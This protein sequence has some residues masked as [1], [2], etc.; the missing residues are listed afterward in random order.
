MEVQEEKVRPVNVAEL[1]WLFYVVGCARKIMFS[2][3]MKTFCFQCLST[4]SPFGSRNMSANLMCVPSSLWRTAGLWVLPAWSQGSPTP[5]R[6]PDSQTGGDREQCRAHVRYVVT[7][8]RGRKMGCFTAKCWNPAKKLLHGGW[9]WFL[10]LN[11]T[12][13]L[14]SSTPSVSEWWCW[15]TTRKCFGRI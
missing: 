1:L 10:S 9:L 13:A 3:K 7:V 6:C 15:I 12:H 11:F 5:G 2:M 14:P 4:V 8:R